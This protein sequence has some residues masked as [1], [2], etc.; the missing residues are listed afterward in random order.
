VGTASF[1]PQSF[2]RSAKLSRNRVDNTGCVGKYFVVPESDYPPAL[3]V[4]IGCATLIS[5]DVHGMLAAIDFN[6]QHSPDA[7]KVDDIWPDWMLPPD[8]VGEFSLAQRP[9]EA[10][11][12]VC[13]VT[14]KLSGARGPF[15]YRH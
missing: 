10:L 6:G 5:R 9:P 13:R 12:S 3:L 11:L 1:P 15:P 8:L 14:A 7:S 4:Q 2:R